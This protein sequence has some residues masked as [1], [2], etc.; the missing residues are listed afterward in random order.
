MKVKRVGGDLYISCCIKC[1]LF[2]RLNG[3]I[4]QTK[5]IGDVITTFVQINLL[6]FTF[7][8]CITLEATYNT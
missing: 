8:K 1:S 6:I 7:G 5:K 2:I 4:S 3:I